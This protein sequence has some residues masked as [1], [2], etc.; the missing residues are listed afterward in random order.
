MATDIFI[1]HMLL[2]FGK[3]LGITPICLDENDTLFRICAKLYLSF[4]SIMCAIGTIFTIFERLNGFWKF[5]NRT[6]IILESLQCPSE[7]LF[8]LSCFLTSL[9]KSSYWKELLNTL[10]EIE[11]HLSKSHQKP[12]RGVIFCILKLLILQV[13]FVSIHVYEQ[14][15]WSTKENESTETGYILSRLAMYYKFIVTIIIYLFAK[16]M[17]RKYK[18]INKLLVDL[19]ASETSCCIE[20]KNNNKQFK[21]KLFYI[22][23]LYATL[24]RIVTIFNSLF[25][26][27]IFFSTVSNVLVCLVNINYALQFSDTSDI[28]FNTGIFIVTSLY[29]ITYLVSTN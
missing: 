14:I 3:I 25:G 9:N 18:D 27:P 23:T 16:N 4:L 28:D 17:K 29:T 2:N 11:N 6:Q 20:W 22:K 7:L 8:L 5:T 24:N 21:Q 10:Y 15:N 26:W 19:V 12:F 13:I 1:F